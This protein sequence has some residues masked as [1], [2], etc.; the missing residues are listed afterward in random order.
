MGEGWWKMRALNWKSDE[1]V[2][3]LIDGMQDL[4]VEQWELSKE[5]KKLS[6]TV[7]HLREVNT[8]INEETE[9]MKKENVGVKEGLR[10][11]MDWLIGVQS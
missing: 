2:R 3:K 5:F 10:K 8:R 6:E 4:K 7:R 9:Q 1:N 11:I